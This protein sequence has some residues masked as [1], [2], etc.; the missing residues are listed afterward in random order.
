MKLIEAVRSVCDEARA[1]T[2]ALEEA[3][4]DSIRLGAAG[5]VEAV[6]EV[7][8][9]MQLELSRRP[10]VFGGGFVAEPERF[11][12]ELMAWWQAIGAERMIRRLDPG[13][14]G[15][16]YVRS[17]VD[18]E[19]FRVPRETG[20]PHMTGPYI[21]YL[22]TDEATLTFTAPFAIDGEFQGVLGADITLDLFE[23]GV[24]D[25]L[26]ATPRALVLTHEHRVVASADPDVLVQRRLSPLARD[27]YAL[28]PVPGTALFIATPR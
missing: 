12:G 17:Y 10:L 11:G 9:T 27:E 21:D 6:L 14:T 20:A 2:R 5:A 7:E 25:A 15:N 13:A 22:C 16:G 26:E 18:I 28:T 8:R 23:R 24:G 3:A 1:V 19:W 4:S